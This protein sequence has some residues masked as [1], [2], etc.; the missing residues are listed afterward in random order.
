MA[1]GGMYGRLTDVGDDVDFSRSVGDVVV[2]VDDEVVGCD[3][4]DVD[5][6]RG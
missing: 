1:V 6:I 5:A 4:E 3:V 2:I